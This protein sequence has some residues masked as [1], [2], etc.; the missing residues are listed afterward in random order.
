MVMSTEVE[1]KP[2]GVQDVATTRGERQLIRLALKHFGNTL[3]KEQRKSNE[4]G[5]PNALIAKKLEDIHGTPNGGNRPGLLTRLMLPGDTD[6]VID[7]GKKKRADQSQLDLPVGKGGQAG[8]RSVARGTTTDE[9]KADV[10]PGRKNRNG[11][12]DD[13][14]VDEIKSAAKSGK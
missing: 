3:T 12:I 1:T 11:R 6:P 2:D 13:L 7:N 10:I 14:A 9:A 8:D 5:A 4:L